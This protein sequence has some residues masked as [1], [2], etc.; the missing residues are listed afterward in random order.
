MYEQTGK[1]LIDVGEI[2][3]ASTG[4]IL[5]DGGEKLNNNL[6]D[7]YNTFGDQRLNDGVQI[8]YATGYYQK[9][10]S[11]Q[12]GTPIPNGSMIDV[13]NTDSTGAAIVSLSRGKL[14]EG[15]VIVNMNGSVSSS[16]PIVVRAF[17]SFVSLPG[18]L[19]VTQPYCKISC[20]CVS[21]EGG[22]SK[23]DYSVESLFGEKVIPVDK[24][25]SLTS[26]DKEIPLFY[27]NTYDTVKMLIT[28]SSVD[29]TKV[30]ASEILL[31]TD[32]AKKA[33]Y[34]T[35]YAVIRRGHVNE[36]DEILSLDFKY[37][38]DNLVAVANSTTLNMRLAIKFITT[39]KI[40]VA[41]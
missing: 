17:D 39:Q 33:A 40:G 16:K 35:E 15:V 4:D 8:L 36:D 12:L 25:F 21:D 10:T 31:N 9:I 24:T 20:W 29:G 22:I 23:W 37:V 1:K 14:G 19:T 34:F 38:G 3:N 41:Q 26:T 32:W 2:G 18:E 6:N 13:D 11:A 30:K 7:I 27:R 28:A 5:F